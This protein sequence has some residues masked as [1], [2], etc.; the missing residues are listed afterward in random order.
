MRPDALDPDM[1][2][3]STIDPASAPD[4]P[5]VDLMSTSRRWMFVSVASSAITNNP[6]PPNVESIVSPLIVLPRP[7]YTP[8]NGRS[9][10]RLWPIGDQS[11][12]AESEMSAVCRWWAPRQTASGATGEWAQISRSSDEERVLGR[13]EAVGPGVVE[14][15]GREG[16]NRDGR[17]CGHEE[18]ARHAEKAK[19]THDDVLAKG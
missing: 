13:P 12:M 17:G 8:V 3:L 15:T 7:S 14:D 9:P 5:S 16:I 4:T 10:E 1:E 6:R 2:V 19:G 11:L 18:P